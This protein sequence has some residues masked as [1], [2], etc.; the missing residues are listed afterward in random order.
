MIHAV[1]MQQT[2]QQEYAHLIPQRMPI[3]PRLPR[4]RIQRDRQISRKLARKLLHRRKAQHIRRFVLASKLTIQPPQ[5]SIIRQQHVH[6]AR[7]AH[8]PLRFTHKPCQSTLRQP[9][10]GP[11]VP[12]RSLTSSTLQRDH[13]LPW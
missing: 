6:R 1:Q 7:Q 5:R 13:V 4:R 9:G 11:S 10:C 3:L 12:L 8:R 2:M